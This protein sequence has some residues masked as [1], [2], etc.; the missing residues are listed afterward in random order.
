M[1]AEQLPI[2]YSFRRC[3]YAMRARLALYSALIS[4][5]HR[6]IELKNKPT[7]MLQASPKGT[8]PVLILTDNTVLQ[9]S[10]DIMKWALKL[11]NLGTEEHK[12]IQLNDCSFKQALDRYKYPGRYTEEDGADYRQQCTVFIEVLEARLNPFLNGKE[13]GGLDMAIFPFI[14]QFSMVDPQWFDTLPFSAVKT[15]LKMISSSEIFAQ[16]M[17]KHPRWD[18]SQAPLYIS[19]K[20]S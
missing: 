2:L 12:L 19:W 17:A 4:H 15:W 3:P 14:R 16:V 11:N 8:V 7:E 1:S 20:E 9:E 6:E 18:A 10:L 5:E 13:M